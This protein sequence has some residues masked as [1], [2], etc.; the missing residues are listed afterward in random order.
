MCF[1]I[2][3]V[4]KFK[5][6]NDGYGH[7]VGDQVLK[8]V[9]KLLKDTFRAT[10]HPV[11]LGGAFSENGFTD[12]LYNRADVALYVVKGSGR[13]DCRFYEDEMGCTGG[14]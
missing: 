4:D 11:R 12:D 14:Q 9:A 6:I 3:D 2:I 1:L 8:K 10:D 5:L 13:G 7:E